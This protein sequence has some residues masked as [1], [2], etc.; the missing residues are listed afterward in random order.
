MTNDPLT[1]AVYVCTMDLRDYLVG[2]AFDARTRGA[3]CTDE[4]RRQHYH[5]LAA[6]CDD[7]ISRLDLEGHNLGMTTSIEVR[8]VTRGRLTGPL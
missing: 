8:R 4:K 5:R 2:M 1:S 6:Y 7:E 3:A